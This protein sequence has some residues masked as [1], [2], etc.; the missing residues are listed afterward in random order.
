MEFSFYNAAIAV[1]K[2]LK[3]LLTAVAWQ[4]YTAISKVVTP[5]RGDYSLSIDLSSFEISAT[6]SRKSFA[7]IKDLDNCSIT[8]N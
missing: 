2:R 8:E 7:Q 4:L 6:G 3:S 5:H 1:T